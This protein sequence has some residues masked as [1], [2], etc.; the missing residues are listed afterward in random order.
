VNMWKADEEGHGRSVCSSHQEQACFEGFHHWLDLHVGRQN[1]RRELASKDRRIRLPFFMPEQCSV[2]YQ[3]GNDGCSRR[4]HCPSQGILSRKVC[5]LKYSLF[6]S[7]PLIEQEAIRS[8]SSFLPIGS[9]KDS[10]RHYCFSTRPI[11]L[12]TARQAQGQGRVVARDDLDHEE[13]QLW[14]S[15]CSLEGFA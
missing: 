1:S 3:L 2:R 12:V 14:S 7:I 6:C 9:E 15:T 10:R 11:W 8:P 4:L 13:E 5:L